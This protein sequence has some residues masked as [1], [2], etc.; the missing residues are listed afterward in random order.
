VQ[1]PP[2]SQ[3]AAHTRSLSGARPSR[4]LPINPLVLLL[5]LA[6]G[7]GAALVGAST[8]LTART[9]TLIVDGARLD[10]R[11]HQPTVS[12]W[13][14]E[15]GLS[16]AAQDIV[17]PPIDTP[18]RDGLVVTLDR[19]HVVIVEADGQTRRVSTRG[20]QPQA[21]LPE[22]GVSVGVHDVI[23]V[24]HA[25]LKQ[26]TYPTA[27][28]VIQVNRALAVRLDDDGRTSTIFTVHRTVGEALH[29]A[30]TVLYLADSVTPAVAAPITDGSTIT[31][32][33]STPVAI[34]VDGRTLMT[35]T[36]GQT[37]GA[38]LAEV[39]I[40]LVGLDYV[41]PDGATAFV[42]GATI[43]VVRVTEEDEVITRTPVDFKRVAKPDPT[44]PLDTR[45]VIQQ[46]IVGIVEQR[47]HIR[48][49]DGL[50][51]SRSA[52]EN[53]VV[54][55]ARD[56]ITAVGTLPELKTLNTP[57]GPVQ[58]WRVLKMRSV[59][60]K[61]SSAGRDPGDPLYGITAT[62]QRLRKGLVAVDPKIIPL[63]TS[64]YVP[65]YGLAVAADTG[66]AVQGLVIDLGYGDDDYQAWSGPVD[67]YLLPPVPPADQ[68][69][70]LE[71]A[72]QP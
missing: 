5:I 71:E 38:V 15:L 55:T 63:G 42:Q 29:D 43:R 8:V 51:V 21:I 30:G 13:L 66:G 25:D 72:S 45:Q 68:I 64:L 50:E 59:S 35:R 48:R 6:I 24:D 41:V 44:L 16:L 47:V 31:V 67:V 52:V 7:L 22:A 62:G 28:N 12:A 27:P 4:R 26:E 9:V 37:V 3:R 56:E 49:E 18:I 57:D 19:A 53:V 33:R 1:K 60:Y 17:S 65:G 54:Q 20:T 36:H 58:Y 34:Q 2:R 39:G 69:P 70:I 11:T 14:A 32:R 10:T 23:R 40:A 46:G 61:P